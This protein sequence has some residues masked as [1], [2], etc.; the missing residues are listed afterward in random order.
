MNPAEIGQALNYTLGSTNFSIDSSCSNLHNDGTQQI[1]FDR[2]GEFGAATYMLEPGTYV[3]VMTDM[4]LDLSPVTSQV[5]A[6]QDASDY[7]TSGE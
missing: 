4:G 3:F 1:V 5:T 6:D 2:G 7:A